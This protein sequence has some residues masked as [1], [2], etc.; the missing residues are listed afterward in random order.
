MDLDFLTI[1]EFEDR[2]WTRLKQAIAGFHRD[3][4][5]VHGHDWPSARK[6]VHDRAAQGLH[7]TAHP[8]ESVHE[9]E[10]ELMAALDA[11]HTNIAS[12]PNRSDRDAARRKA[13]GQLRGE[14]NCSNCCMGQF[15][16]LTDPSD[17]KACMMACEGGTG[18]CQP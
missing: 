12:I 17:F 2:Y 8:A 7:K 15:S 6:R 16:P 1:E 13:S 4:P 5:T 9:L 11:F 18:S 3:L 14:D 10:T